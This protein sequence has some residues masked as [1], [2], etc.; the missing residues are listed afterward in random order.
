M[1]KRFENF[2]IRKA[3][4]LS[5]FVIIMVSLFSIVSNF[6][7]MNFSQAIKLAI[8]F[9]FSDI[10]IA[11]TYFIPISSKIKGVF[12]SIV[13]LAGAIA[14]LS[15]D[16]TD[17]TA[18]YA[19][20]AS[21][22]I[23]ALYFSK[24]MIIFYGIVINAVFITLFFTDNVLLFG[25][26]RPISYLISTLI[27][28]DGIFI[29]LFFNNIWG[30]QMIVNANNKEKE[31][32]SLMEKLKVTMEKI[33]SSSVVLNKN[34]S[35]LDENVE[36]IVKSSEETTKA[37]GDISIGTQNQAESINNI[38]INMSSAMGEV[39][40]TKELSEKISESSKDISASV[41]QGSEKVNAMTNQM[42]TI[43]QAISVA[44]TTVNELQ[45]NIKNI[46][47]SLLGITQISDQINL[48][49]LNAAI[50]AAR[51]GEH[52]KGF[53]VVAEEVKKLAEQSSIIVKDI[54][55]TIDDISKKTTTAVNMVGQGES[56]VE[57]GN[58]LI[59]E[60]VQHFDDV[61]ASVENTFKVLNREKTMVENM[62]SI[63]E[64]VQS[65]MENITAISE[66]HVATNEE[67]L[68][69]IESENSDI[70]LINNSIKDIKQLSE[71]LKNMLVI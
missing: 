12:Y 5:I 27:T 24:E 69:T 25:T 68:A 56:A 23:L 42:H 4:R 33:E 36:E 45:A 16:P 43:N 6:L 41:S 32:N 19:I 66:E 59:E 29:I 37:L 55:E 21:I 1:K 40:A 13:I 62:Y 52:G 11:A 31:A 54:N 9:I 26:T 65:Q 57:S 50:E 3:D 14:S 46:N 63:F 53:A 60:V 70:M 30:Q 15:N 39:T 48:L 49:A 34:I 28:V 7:T 71:E 20:A 18:Q 10:I 47:S 2:Q 58:T 8:P 38:S 67:V 17:Q 35:V 51:A 44:L 61:Q 64:K 22:I